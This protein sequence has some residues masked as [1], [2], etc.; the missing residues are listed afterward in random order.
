MVIETCILL[1][2]ATVAQ[3]EE[4]LENVVKIVIRKMLQQSHSPP[5]QKPGKLK[6]FM[7]KVGVQNINQILTLHCACKYLQ[8]SV[9]RECPDGSLASGAVVT[10]TYNYFSFPCSVL[11]TEALAWRM[12]TVAACLSSGVEQVTAH[13][14]S[15]ESFP[16][17]SDSRSQRIFNTLI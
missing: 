3:T 11:S 17:F 8:Y 5:E 7:F 6:T 15:A 16:L 12:L 4:L 10:T 2:A 13:D 9:F 14:M 1:L